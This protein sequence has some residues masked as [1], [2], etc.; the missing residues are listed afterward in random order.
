MERHKRWVGLMFTMPTLIVII[1]VIMLPLLWSL[2]AS[3]SDYTFI[4]PVFDNFVG[5]SNYLS[6]MKSSHFWNSIIQTMKFVILVVTLEFIL[7][8]FIALLLDQD[9]RFKGFY[10]TIL[11]IPMV[12]SPI[13]VA[14]IWKMILHAEL[15]VVNHFISSIGFQ[16]VDWFGFGRTAFLSLILVDV[17]HQMSFMILVLLAGLVSLPKEPF[18]A[19][20]IDGASAWQSFFLVKVPLLKP[21]IFTAILIRLITAFKTYDLVYIL[22][23]GGPGA[24]TDILSYYIYKTTF[25]GLN[26][27]Q[28][29]A[30]SY[31]LMIFVLLIV[32]ILFRFLTQQENAY[33]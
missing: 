9:I 18:E 14:L 3:L 13:T 4:H 32:M 7:G 30:M 24:T 27:S 19:A 31:M 10:Y 33:E 2:I 23:K 11:T 6:V 29:S 12:M 17:W 28:A 25:M 22:T 8:F 21:V 26:I 15:G 1:L 16:P 5:L 20:L